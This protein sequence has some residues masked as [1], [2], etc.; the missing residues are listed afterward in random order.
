MVLASSFE[1]VNQGWH[2]DKS[3]WGVIQLSL[4]FTFQEIS[5]RPETVRQALTAQLSTLATGMRFLT[6]DQQRA[7]QFTIHQ[8]GADIITIR[9]EG[10]AL[11]RV[12]LESFVR[13]VIHLHSVNSSAASPCIIGSSNRDPV[14]TGLCVIA[15]GPNGRIRVINYVLPIL[16]FLGWACISGQQMPNT[17]WLDPQHF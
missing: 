16:Q 7:R 3:T 12:P 15:R 13:T 1:R 9:T 4:R 14:R 2:V 17:A 8:H 10:G 6:P 11:V 5:M